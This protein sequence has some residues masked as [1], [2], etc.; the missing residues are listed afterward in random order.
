MP[1]LSQR[2]ATL[3]ERCDEYEVI[4]AAVSWAARQMLLQVDQYL[5]DDAEAQ[6]RWSRLSLK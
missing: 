1:E 2:I 5:A 3:I 6:S 4:L